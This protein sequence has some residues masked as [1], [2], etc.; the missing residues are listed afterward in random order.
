MLKDIKIDGGTQWIY[1]M[2]CGDGVGDT[3][4]PSRKKAVSHEPKSGSTPVIASKPEKE[5]QPSPVEEVD[6]KSA[7]STPSKDSA[8]LTGAILNNKVGEFKGDDSDTTQVPNNNDV[9]KPIEA[10]E[11]IEAII[12]KAENEWIFGF[13]T[14]KSTVSRARQLHNDITSLVSAAGVKP[15]EAARQAA[16]TI[17]DITNKVR[18][19]SVKVEAQPGD[20]DQLWSALDDLED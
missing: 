5:V 8:P 10:I 14:S 18:Y 9:A 16:S 17:D 3:T 13:K 15:E 1:D 12:T 19:T 6:E 4:V 2:L 20:L 11:A 7:D